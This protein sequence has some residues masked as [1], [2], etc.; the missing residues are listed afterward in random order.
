MLTMTAPQRRT[1]GLLM[2]RG[3]GALA[4]FAAV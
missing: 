2:L 4:G 3:F 1:P